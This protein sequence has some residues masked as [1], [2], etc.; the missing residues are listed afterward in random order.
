MKNGIAIAVSLVGGALIGGALGL[1]FAP[2]MGA[3]T[4]SKIAE[5]LK[6]NGIN[7]RIRRWMSSSTTSPRR[8]RKNNQLAVTY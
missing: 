4:R 6:K 7:L 2:A 8:L 1:L 3:D 5:I